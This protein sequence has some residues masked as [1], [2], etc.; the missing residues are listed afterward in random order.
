MPESN[1]TRPT[2]TTHVA[3]QQAR[4]FIDEIGFVLG[5]NGRVV[6]ANH[7]AAVR[8][9]KMMNEVQPFFDRLK[10]G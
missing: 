1:P 7:E 5:P 9:T 6:A 3:S 2:L 10:L 8:L 4:S